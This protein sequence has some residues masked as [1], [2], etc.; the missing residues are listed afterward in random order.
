MRLQGQYFGD[1]AQPRKVWTLV[2]KP[3]P[4]KAS[5]LTLRSDAGQQRVAFRVSFLAERQLVEGDRVI[6][7]LPG[8]EWHDSSGTPSMQ[9]RDLIVG[10]RDGD[11]FDGREGWLPWS[12]AAGGEMHF[13]VARSVPLSTAVQFD[14]MWIGGPKDSLSKPKPRAPIADAPWIAMRG[15]SAT[16]PAG[17]AGVFRKAPV[18]VVVDNGNGWLNATGGAPAQSWVPCEDVVWKSQDELRCTVPAGGGAPSLIR[19]EVG[20]QDSNI[21]MMPSYAPPVIQ[22]VQPQRGPAAGGY[23]LTINGTHF[24]T[25]PD[26]VDAIWIGQAECT[27][28]RWLSGGSVTCVAPPGFGGNQSILVH[29]SGQYSRA[30]DLQ[31]IQFHYESPRVL[32]VCPNHGSTGDDVLVFGEN[33]GAARWP[34]EHALKSEVRS[35]PS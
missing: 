8:L 23:Q 18:S 32:D 7:G 4:L 1:S 3:S 19:V 28:V 6:L 15:G 29:V 30:S 12:D 10:G 21:M 22:S 20:A 34:Q 5:A 16:M 27:D 24:G 14:V 2:N 26:W 31:P 17:A 13:R 35:S 25:T 33:F 11:R 9:P